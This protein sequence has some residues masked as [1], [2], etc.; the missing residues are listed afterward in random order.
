MTSFLLK[1]KMMQQPWVVDWAIIHAG[2][3][4]QAQ[5]CHI[6]SS[7]HYRTPYSL[8]VP[9]TPI[10][11]SIFWVINLMLLIVPQFFMLHC[12]GQVN[13]IVEDTSDISKSLKSMGSQASLDAIDRLVENAT[14]NK[15]IALHSK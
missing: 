2:A 15:M 12:Q 9:Q 1:P 3:A 10:Y 7:L 13:Q 5:F 4:A 14:K 8:R 11:C 6:G